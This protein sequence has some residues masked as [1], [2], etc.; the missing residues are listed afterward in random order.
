M[1]IVS[2]ETLIDD[3]GKIYMD[4]ILDYKSIRF[5]YSFGS[6]TSSWAA[7]VR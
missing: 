6:W 2:L 5:G 3:D 1:Q 4:A 7:C